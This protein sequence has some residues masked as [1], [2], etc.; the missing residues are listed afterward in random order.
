M[1]SRSY[2]LVVIGAGIVGLSTALSAAKS[3][4]KSILCVDRYGVANS[5]GASGDVS[6]LFRVSYFEHPAYVPM[7][8]NAIEAWKSLG[9]DLYVPAGGLYAGPRDSELIWGALLSAHQHD[10]PHDEL[11]SAEVMARFPHFDLPSHY[12]GFFEPEAGFVR[13]DKATRVVAAAA[14]KLGVAIQI[15]TVQGLEPLGKRWSVRYDDSEVIADQVIVAAGN[16][17]ACLVPQVASHLS[18]QTH[19]VVWLEPSSGNWN[20]VPGFGIMNEAA[21]M[22]YGFPVL[23]EKLGVKI[24]G[25]H[26]FSADSVAQQERGLLRLAGQFLPGLTNTIL[27]RRTCD[28][29]MSP[30]GNFLIG[31]IEPGL[32]VACGFSGHGYKFGSVIGDLVWQAAATGLPDELS[33]LDVIRFSWNSSVT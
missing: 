31:R 26:Q 8:R 11:T 32:S 19:L 6:R 1:D 9:D 10:L 3:G 33:F 15:G 22:L 28:Y 17:T 13:S 23:E 5:S 4:I 25:H 29:D 2:D 30:D 18:R 27:S 14:E 7:L 16:E 24:G 20:H 21:E 12:V